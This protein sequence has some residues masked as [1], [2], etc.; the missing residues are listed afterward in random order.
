VRRPL[1]HL[2]QTKFVFGRPPKN[3]DY[4]F[5]H[6]SWLGRIHFVFSELG[7]RK[8]DGFVECFGIDLGRVLVLLTTNQANRRFCYL[9][10]GKHYSKNGQ[11]K[12]SFGKYVCG[13]NQFGACSIE[14]LDGDN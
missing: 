6:C 3:F 13:I 11:P 2:I 8:R 14:L 9:N 5:S 10:N 1:L 7:N 4:E 12:H